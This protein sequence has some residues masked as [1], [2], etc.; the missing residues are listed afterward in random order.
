[1]AKKSPEPRSIKNRRASFD[2]ELGDDLIVGLSLTGAETKAL[3]KGQGNLKG[4]Y[5]TVHDE[6][7]WLLNATITGD[8]QVKVEEEQQTRSRKILA[9]RKEI[10]ILIKQKKSGTSI[11]PT[12]IL[13]KG[14]Y[15][16]LVIALGKGK[17]HTDKRQTIKKRE[18]NIDAR[19]EIKLRSR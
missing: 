17:K 10:D 6:E 9:K 3:R 4:A 14:K 7:L 11:V 12:K 2:Y 19:R 5:V 1:M 8:N 16:K 13:N 15:I 18:A